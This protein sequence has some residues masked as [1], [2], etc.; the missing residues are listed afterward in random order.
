MRIALV[1][2][3]LTLGL[4]NTAQSAAPRPADGQ[5]WSAAKVA[6]SYWSARTEAVQSVIA[7]RGG[8]Y[9][10]CGIVTPSIAS[11]PV[12]KDYAEGEVT[13]STAYAWSVPGSCA[14][15]LTPHFA[16]VTRKTRDWTTRFDLKLECAVTT[17]EYGHGLGLTHE[18]AGTFALMAE[19]HPDDSAIPG[20]CGAWSKRIMREWKASQR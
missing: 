2:L 1:T 13:A 5:L 11:P 20:R 7:A 14:F 15:A 3:A 18:D 12:P 4:T 17:H 10:A 16:A 19:G 6:Q 8:T 9:A